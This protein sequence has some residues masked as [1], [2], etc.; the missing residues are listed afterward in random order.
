MQNGRGLPPAVN[1]T[2]TNYT[3]K[4][5][6]VSGTTVSVDPFI[7]YRLQP[8]STSGTP[9][10]DVRIS[11]WTTTS[12]TFTD[13]TAYQL[14]KPTYSFLNVT[15]THYSARITPQLVGMGH[16][17]V[18]PAEA[19]GA[20]RAHARRQRSAQKTAAARH[21]HGRHFDVDDRVLAQH[22]VHRREVNSA[23][24]TRLHSTSSNAAP[25]SF[26]AATCSSTT[27]C[28][29]SVGRRESTRR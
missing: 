6:R 13:G 22:G 25:R 26:T 2:L 21:P 4:V 20:C 10:A 23:E 16:H 14:R 9:E 24:F 29:P 28:S 11:G 1:T 17:Q 5:G 19:N 18:V 15:P 12:G 7:G 27:R 8:R 3:V